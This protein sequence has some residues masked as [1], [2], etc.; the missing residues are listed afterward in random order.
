MDRQELVGG[1]REPPAISETHISM[2]V[3]VGDRVYKFR[4]PVDLGYVD[5]RE[6]GAREADCR[7]EV[8]LNRHFA[9]DVYLGVGHVTQPDGVSEPMVVMRR[10]PASRSLA[11]L[12]AS[13]ADIT[14]EIIAV[15]RTLAALHAGAPRSVEISGAASP[16]A[17]GL[18]WE[19]LFERASTHLAGV[20]D[21]EVDRRIQPLVARYLAGRGRLF[22][23]RIAK[24]AICEG[25]GDLQAADIF[26]L[27]DGPRLLDCVEFDDRLRWLDQ[28]ADVA[29]LVMDL[30]RLGAPEAAAQLQQRYVEF[31]ADEAPES[32]L[33][34]WVA[35]RAY[36]RAV[37]TAERAV[38][39]KPAASPGLLPDASGE[40]ARELQARALAHLER[41][42]IRLVLVG[43][44]PGSGKSTLS[45]AFANARGWTVLRTD[46]IRR[47]S[48]HEDRYAPAATAA[49]YA[50]LLRRAAA[51]LRLGESVVLDA[52]WRQESERGLARRVAEE[53]VSEIVEIECVCNDEEA[54]RRILARLAAAGSAPDA[55]EATPSVRRMLAGSFDA[56]PEATI[57]DTDCSP[58]DSLRA[59]QMV[60]ERTAAARMGRT[61]QG[62]Q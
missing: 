40:L 27:E 19:S 37:V 28:V 58:S 14:E 62:G 5:F 60:V 25:H 38:T 61:E 11:A 48:E 15:A 12:V 24:G 39:A 16:A 22:D 47:E 2:L 57:V 6:L 10:L 43:G 21:P 26:C 42:L 41:G 54:E 44:L 35:E 3:F 9:P 53:T 52:T 45:D 13:G 31:A 56:W 20:L 34:F 30:E 18:L 32:F 46:E 8:E 55:S 50:E 7:R 51:A 17:V 59:A 23:T 1:S 49:V 33:D 36:V 29:F 4:K